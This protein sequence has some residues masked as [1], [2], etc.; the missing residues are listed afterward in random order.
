MKK[1]CA[2][3]GIEYNEI[4][5]YPSWNGIKLDNQYPWGTIGLP[6]LKEQEERIKELSSEEKNNIKMISKYMAEKF[7]YNL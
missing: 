3:T 5:L 4:L 6:D 2:S 7:N 1:L